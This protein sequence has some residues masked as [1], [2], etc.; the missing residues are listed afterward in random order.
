[1]PFKASTSIFA[2]LDKFA[3]APFKYQNGR[4]GLPM[5]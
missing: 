2:L 5:S 3:T 1:M 4:E